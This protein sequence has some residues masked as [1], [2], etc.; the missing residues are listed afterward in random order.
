MVIEGIEDEEVR[1]VGV[2]EICSIDS[3]EFDGDWF[4]VGV[5]KLLFGR[6]FG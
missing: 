6:V 5:L 3:L 2:E 1:F 4:R